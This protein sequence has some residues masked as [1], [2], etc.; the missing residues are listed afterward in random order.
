MTSPLLS[1][2]IVALAPSLSRFAVF[3][4]HLQIENG[5]FWMDIA[6]HCHANPCLCWKFNVA[7]SPEMFGLRLWLKPWELDM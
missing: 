6:F 7:F 2:W 3:N 5:L 1:Q 4:S